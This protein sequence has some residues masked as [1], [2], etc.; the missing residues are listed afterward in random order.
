MKKFWHCFYKVGGGPP[1]R[2]LSGPKGIGINNYEPSACRINFAVPSMNLGI[3][4]KEIHQKSS[5]QVFLIQLLKKLQKQ[6][7]T[8][9]KNLYFLTMGNLL[10]QG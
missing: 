4:M 5:A 3:L 10:E 9:P 7:P 1:L 8:H 6:F 2:L